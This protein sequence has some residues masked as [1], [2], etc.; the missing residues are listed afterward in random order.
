MVD[1]ALVA[2]IGMIPFVKPGRGAVYAQIGEG[3]ARAALSD[4]GIDYALVQQA[5]V[6]FVY[7]DSA[8]GQAALYGLGHTLA[9]QHN[10][11]L[12]GACVVTLYETVDT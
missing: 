11:G 2:G 1:D 7:G 12:G 10:L 4:A 5:Y 8:S 3:A 6:G 9:L